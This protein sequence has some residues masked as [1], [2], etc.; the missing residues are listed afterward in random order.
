MLKQYDYHVW[1]NERVFHHLRSL[2]EGVIH[3]SIQSVFP[4]VATVL[5]HVYLTETIWLKVMDGER[6]EAIEE[7]VHRDKWT[8]AFSGESL[9]EIETL[10]AKLSWRYQS[11]FEK[12]PD[13]TKEITIEH[14]KFG[15][16]TLPISELLQHLVNHASYH[17]GNLTAM[18]RQ[19]GL[20]GI[21]TDYFLYLADNQ[22]G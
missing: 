19:L 20:G 8:Q 2:P 11:Y 6:F 12:T 21:S 9:E 10:Y 17:R 15:R 5:V 7:Y 22:K 1:A 13:L 4:T 3:Q 16:V 14:P 18:L